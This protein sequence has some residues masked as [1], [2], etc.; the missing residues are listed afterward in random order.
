M[1][2]SIDTLKTELQSDVA[3][4]H[5]VDGCYQTIG[6][7]PEGA[8]K[9]SSCHTTNNKRLIVKE[10]IR[11]DDEPRHYRY[12]FLV[13]DDKASCET[14]KPK[15]AKKKAKKDDD[16]LVGSMTEQPKS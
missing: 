6:E 12:G 5:H 13:L 14:P 11:L 7:L 10:V 16:E 2:K 1:R 15:K 4:F 8:V 3:I 9:G